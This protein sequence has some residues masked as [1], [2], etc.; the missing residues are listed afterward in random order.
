M[1]FLLFATLAL[2][3]PKEPT[4]LISLQEGHQEWMTEAQ[5]FKLLREK[6]HF[7]DVTGG[8]WDSIASFSSNS[9]AEPTFPTNM[10][11]QATVNNINSKI[12]KMWVKAFVDGMAAF[13]NR[14]YTS[15]TGVQSAQFVYDQLVKIANETR[16]TDVR[17][18]VEKFVHPTWPQFSVIA[19]L[20]SADDTTLTERIV[21][22]AHQDS[23]NSRN[24]RTGR[25]PGYDDDG[26]GCANNAATL[27]LLL[28][29]PTFVPKR[30]IEFHFYAAEEAGL[31]GSQE[32]VSKYVSTGVQVYGMLNSDM[33]G[34]PTSTPQYAIVT[35]FA[36]P[37]LTEVLR[38][39]AKTYQK[40]PIVD[41]RCGYGCSDHASWHRANIPVAHHH[42][43][44]ARTHNPQI[45][46][47]GDTFSLIS[48]DHAV[49][50][51]KATVG[52]VVEMSLF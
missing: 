24:P 8:H 43:A 9:F 11:R 20:S 4:Y 47:T 39:V 29:D 12:D 35:D 15:D 40:L 46:T 38:M 48:L 45:H 28:A 1:K 37:V 16:R 49:E 22:G 7:I 52:F 6:K 26:T 23:I 27:K 34:Y 32:I 2:C 5:V 14:Y 13:N 30:P 51:L 50:F 36:N 25:A 31:K 41:T 17:V 33:T 18:T 19:R 3:A 44:T 42:E 10:T 21:L